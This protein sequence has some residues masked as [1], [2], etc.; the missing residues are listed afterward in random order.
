[1]DVDKSQEENTVYYTH[2]GGLYKNWE[3]FKFNYETGSYEP[4]TYKAFLVC[5]EGKKDSYTVADGTERINSRSFAGCENLVSINIPASV[6]YIAEFFCVNCIS[7]TDINVD[8]E[9]TVY[10]SYNGG[11]YKNHTA[12]TY[13]SDTESYET[14]VY[15]T[16][17]VCPE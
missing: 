1:A 11:L 4:K 6:T 15:K 17:L 14:A 13:N 9:N 3:T 5:P 8:E 16:F 12:S 7:L 10:Y 2:D